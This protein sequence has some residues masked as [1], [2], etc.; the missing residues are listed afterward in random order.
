MNKQYKEKLTDY[1]PEF[2]D[3]LRAQLDKDQERWGDTWKK[4][5]IIGQ[6]DRVFSMFMDYYDQYKNANTEIPYLKIAGEAL[7]CWVRKLELE[8]QIENS[9]VEQSKTA[10]SDGE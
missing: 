6:D 1:L 9:S 5:S 3:A 8:K 10:N 4:R 7:I 2:M